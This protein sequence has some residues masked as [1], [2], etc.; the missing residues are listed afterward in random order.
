MKKTDFQKKI[1]E[2]QKRLEEIYADILKNVKSDKVIEIPKKY[3][4]IM[5][6]N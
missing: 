4:E 2:Q 5:C 3:K 1:E 6:P